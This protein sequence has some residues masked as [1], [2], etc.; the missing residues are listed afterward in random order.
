[1]VSITNK[2]IAQLLK[3]VAATYAIKNEKKYY[4]QMLAYQKA[5]EV[6]DSMPTQVSDLYKENKLDE[7][8]GVGPGIRA[9]LEELLKTSK[10]KHFEDIT[11]DI[12]KSMFTLL[13]IP[14]LGPKKAYRLTTEFH[15]EDPETVIEDIEKLA[16]ENKIAVLTGFGEKSQADILRAIAEYRKGAGKTTRMVL[17]YAT[18]IAESVIS[19]LKKSSAIEEALP[20]GSLR[21]KKSTIG[22]IDIAVASN[23]PKEAIEHFLAYPY[24]ARNIEQ[25]PTTASMLLTNG[26]QIDLMVQPPDSF[27]SLLQHFT[28]S[29][30][31]NVHLR[32]YA[33]KKGYSLS[34]Y[35]IRPKNNKDNKIAKKFKTE[36]E[37]YNF[38]GLDWIPPEIR[39]DSGEIEL[40]QKHKLP[41]LITLL[42]IK[43]DLHL[44]SSYPIEPSHDM[45][46]SS[47]KVMLDEAKKLGYEY[48]GFSEHNPSTG[49]HTEDEIYTLL[50]KRKEYITKLNE[51]NKDVRV[52]SLLETDIQPNGKLAISEK[53][54]AQLDATL[55]SIH[56][57]FKMNKQEM[58]KRVLEGLSHPKAK[59]LT[60][61]TGRLINTRPGY[62]LDF[63]QIF[64][65][66]VKNNKAIEINSWPQRLDLPDNLVKQGIKYGVK[67][68]IDTDS[69][70]ANHMRFM[71]FGV[72]L[73]RRGWATKDD[74]LNT[75][76]YNKF[77]EWL[78]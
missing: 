13:T 11:K 49:N 22:D 6:I 72:D 33:L 37:F 78:I 5:A 51:N 50:K 12:P 31:H 40:A 62:E 46:R 75:L 18:Q 54:L 65:F 58:T 59:I 20:L 48:I 63:D 55:V 30:E 17:P 36:E 42:E 61:P 21:R 35:G 73:A 34:E 47:M 9:S 56:S 71:R 14:S 60:H 2:E 43:G 76:P 25:G 23:K 15:L 44:H 19:Y 26:A 29:K 8:P 53:N 4:F 66:C 45:G 32:E 67:F 68:V 10:V 39:E 41:Q 64:D 70:D 24:K 3:N 27:G 16:K 28:G 77:K 57:V 69:H 1:M 7:I 74:I 52:F 38:L